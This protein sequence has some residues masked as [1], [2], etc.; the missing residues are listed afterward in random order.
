ML[1]LRLVFLLAP[2]YP[3]LFILF[4]SFLAG[5]GHGEGQIRKNFWQLRIRMIMTW[6][7][8]KLIVFPVLVNAALVVSGCAEMNVK[9]PSPEVK[10]FFVSGREADFLSTLCSSSAHVDL[11]AYSHLAGVKYPPTLKVDILTQ[12]PSRPYKP[13][14]VLEY[15]PPS[16]SAPEA[17]MEGL[18]NKAREIGADALIICRPG[19]NSGLSGLPPSTKMQAVAIKYKLTREPG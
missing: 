19:E 4:S 12:P 2:G 10:T 9:S 13:F 14:A 3:W 6:A 15:E 1:R 18:K 5:E 17:Q 16:S 8:S 11:S 7:S